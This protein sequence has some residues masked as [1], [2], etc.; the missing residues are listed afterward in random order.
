MATETGL[1]G[2]SS[3]VAE[4]GTTG[5]NPAFGRNRVQVTLLGGFHLAFGERDVSLPVGAQRLVAM[6]A[7]RGRLSRSRT[8]GT[9][10]PDTPEPRALASLR[11]GIWRVNQAAPNLVVSTSGQVEL[12]TRAQVDVRV[13]IA[14]SVEIMRGGEMDVMTLSVGLSDG[15]LLPDWDDG[16]LGDERERLHQLRMHV[17]ENVAERLADAGQFGLAIEVALAVTRADMLRESAH[18]VLVRVHLAEGNLNEARRAYS[19]CERVLH[20]ELGV[21]PTAAMRALFA[22]RPPL[23]VR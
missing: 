20:N 6:L 2:Q 1:T 7:L 8:A 21:A 14:R 13:L 11:T 12:D 19:T 9:L 3:Q 4:N 18:R 15:E 22:Q 5:E 16:W 10:W 17:L 23:L